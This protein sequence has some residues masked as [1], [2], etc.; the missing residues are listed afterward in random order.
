[1]SDPEPLSPAP[2]S[3]KDKTAIH[4]VALFKAA[5]FSPDDEHVISDDESQ[6]SELLAVQGSDDLEEIFELEDIS[7]ADDPLLHKKIDTAKDDE[8]DFSKEMS[9]LADS[10]GIDLMDDEFDISDFDFADENE[11][12]QVG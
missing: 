1:M 5:G 9:N 4:D 3:K 6:L 11:T 10:E 7:A 8:F 12:D 2:A